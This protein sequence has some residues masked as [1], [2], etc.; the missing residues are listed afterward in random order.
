MKYAVNPY[1]QSVT[2]FMYLKELN[3]TIFAVANSIS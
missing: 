3:L 2:A 1:A